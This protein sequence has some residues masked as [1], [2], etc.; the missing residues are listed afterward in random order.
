M[1][2]MGLG[3]V[4]AFCAALLMNSSIIGKATADEQPQEVTVLVAARPL[5]AVSVLTD[6]DVRE[7]TMLV[8]KAPQ[9]RIASKTQVIGRVLTTAVVAGQPFTADCFPPKTDGVYLA[10]KLEPGQRAVTVALSEHG[11]LDRLLY[12]GCIVD[13]L[14]A[15]K[16]PTDRQRGGEGTAVSTTLIQNVQVLAVEDR[17]LAGEQSSDSVTHEVQE[18]AEKAANTRRKD[19]RV[20]LLVD[21]R[22]AEA[23][24]LAQEHGS[25]SLAMRNP[26]DASPTQQDPTVLHEGRLARL[27]EYLNS[28]G[29]KD[30]APESEAQGQTLGYVEPDEAPAAQPA[31]RKWEVMVMRGAKAEIQT[32]APLE[33]D[34][35]Q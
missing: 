22:Q 2:L 29:E 4:A 24:Q 23:L 32:L 10:S 19:L 9:R 13:V 26:H 6:E 18:K 33:A 25:I 3:L 34:A 20:T 27:A 7:E 30:E 16:L 21:S 5:P 12:P 28:F 8:A 1:G 15:F 35:S 11:G 31:Q 17:T 14:A